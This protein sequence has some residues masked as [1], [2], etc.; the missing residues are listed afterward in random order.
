MINPSPGDDHSQKI[1]AT[2]TYSSWKWKHK[3][4][5]DWPEILESFWLTNAQFYH[6]SERKLESV[7][8]VP[9]CPCWDG[10]SVP[11]LRQPSI[12]PMVDSNISSY[13]NLGW[14][15]LIWR[16]RGNGFVMS[17]LVL[18][19]EGDGMP[20]GGKLWGAFEVLRARSL[21]AC[22]ALT[23]RPST[24]TPGTPD[25]PTPDP[26]T[27]PAFGRSGLLAIVFHALQALKV[28][29]PHWWP[30]CQRHCQPPCP[31]PCQPHCH[32]VGHQHEGHI[33]DNVGWG[34]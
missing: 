19:N 11:A 10:A 22:W 8:T 27:G 4:Q 25:H 1:S 6:T 32:L 21:G 16:L 31:T 26:W 33:C 14:C 15:K 3:I 17:P 13:C 18:R 9:D 29:D 23:S 30:P 34:M 12:W 5:T 28:C 24:R 7:G 20:L 2:N